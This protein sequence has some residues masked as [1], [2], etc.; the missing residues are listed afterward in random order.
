MV[1]FPDL[2]ENQL[3]TFQSLGMSQ[4]ITFLSFEMNLLKDFQSSGMSP[5]N[6]F[7]NFEARVDRLLTVEEAL[8]E[9]NL[10][11]PSNLGLLSSIEI[12]ENEYDSSS[13]MMIEG[14]GRQLPEDS[15]QKKR[16]KQL[17]SPK[18][19]GSAKLSKPKIKERKMLVRKRAIPVRLKKRG[20]GLPPDDAE[21]YKEIP[22]SSKRKQSDRELDDED[23]SYPSDPLPE[24]EWLTPASF[25][26]LK[27]RKETNSPGKVTQLGEKAKPVAEKEEEIPSTPPVPVL[28]SVSTSRGRI[29][30]GAI[31]PVKD[32]L[33]SL[34]KAPTPIVRKPLSNEAIDELV[35]RK[36]EIF[37]EKLGGL[38]GSEDSASKDSE[39]KSKRVTWGTN[40]SFAVASTLSFESSASGDVQ[41]ESQKSS[42]TFEG[43]TPKTSDDKENKKEP[44]LFGADVKSTPAADKAP[45]QNAS[46]NITG[47]S[48][49][50]S[51]GPNFVAEKSKSSPSS[52]A[53]P[54]FGTTSTA[55]TTPAAVAFNLP[56]DAKVE[57]PKPAAASITFDFGSK[58]A[59]APAAVVTTAAPAVATTVTP[60]PAIAPTAAPEAK[61]AAGLSFKPAETNVSQPPAAGLSFKPAETSVSQPPAFGGFSFPSAVS[62]PSAVSGLTTSRSAAGAPTSIT[63]P[64]L[65]VA[66]SSLTPTVSSIS[67]SSSGAS[68]RFDMSPKPT[69]T[70]FSGFGGLGGQ[71]SEPA[72]NSFAVSTV[73]PS[74]SGP[75]FGM[76]PA[77]TATST[78]SFGLQLGQAPSVPT[79]GQPA[80]PAT[81]TRTFSFGAA[82]TQAP[83]QAPAASTS[84]TF[85]SAPTSSAPGAEAAKPFAFGQTA[86][87][88][89]FSFGGQPSSAA[90]TT[91]AAPS[92]FGGSSFMTNTSQPTGNAMNLNGAPPAFNFGQPTAFASQPSSLSTPMGISSQS[93]AG[94][95]AFGAP[96]AT[97]ASSS[98]GFSFGAPPS[99]TPST[100]F[101]FGQ[102]QPAAPAASAPFTFGSS[103]TTGSSAGF[104]FGSGSSISQ[105]QPQQQTMSATP[106]TG[107]FNFGASQV[108]ATGM[109]TQTPS[110]TFGAGA[111]SSSAASP[112]FG[113]GGGSPAPFQFGASPSGS[114]GGG[115]NPGSSG[116]RKL[117]QPKARNQRRSSAPGRR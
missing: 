114:A 3:N 51:G 50:L 93:G 52:T 112:A 58:A 8:V 83:T 4:L 36:I 18:V 13:G 9:C 64:T 11:V 97:A 82:P 109:Q 42:F 34:V 74:G 102:S 101:S 113:G 111:G 6:A 85:G 41:T 96:T 31:T 57:P 81:S 110:F 80:A 39:K 23:A 100:T 20:F 73:A 108:P 77:T 1:N 89:A 24:D 49:S 32:R 116:D 75:S 37:E 86:T 72:V 99:A 76:V 90:P 5:H 45:L 92:S 63:A 44:G 43:T 79:F 69:G 16:R 94:S 47:F 10:S 98:T 12:A 19:D 26:K 60:T 38:N 40:E 21:S 15:I 84:F 27:K 59:P 48:S 54:L 105:P 46:F 70:T 67:D 88:P 61:P 95:M 78:P 103:S 55:P 53:V 28:A 65:T 115:F 106:S 117:A 68:F 33:G 62:T 91:A 56:S 87:T 14:A 30:M 29:K 71:K 107:G 35:N 104:N 25:R 17:A 22:T 7:K 66:P 2:F